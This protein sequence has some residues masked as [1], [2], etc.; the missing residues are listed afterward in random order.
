MSSSNWVTMMP[1]IASGLMTRLRL[2][3]LCL[4]LNLET[5]DIRFLFEVLFSLDLSSLHAEFIDVCDILS[6]KFNILGVF[7]STSSVLGSCLIIGVDFVNLGVEFAIRGK[8]VSLALEI[9]LNGDGDPVRS[10]LTE[11]QLCGTRAVHPGFGDSIRSCFTA[12]RFGDDK[13]EAGLFDRKLN[14]DVRT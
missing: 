8:L 7:V 6:G 12:Q 11:Q 5:D 13:L 10:S 9:L 14:I 3:R 1:G 4:V 2:R